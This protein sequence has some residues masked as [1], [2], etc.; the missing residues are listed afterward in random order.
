MEL[1]PLIMAGRLI[2][3]DPA[4][5]E[6]GAEPSYNGR[7]WSRGLEGGGFMDGRTRPWTAAPPGAAVYK[8][9]AGRSLI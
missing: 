7:S 2:T 4:A 3:V 9:A 1:N 8:T 6:R 5:E